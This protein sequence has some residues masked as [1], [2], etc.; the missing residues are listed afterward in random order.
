MNIY[1]IGSFFSERSLNTHEIKKIARRALCSI[2][3][4][5]QCNLGSETNQ[6]KLNKEQIFIQDVAAGVV[7]DW[8]FLN[9]E[10]ISSVF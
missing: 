9:G 3:H 10:F 2:I 1:L 6:Q 7:L 8:Q 4:L 5:L